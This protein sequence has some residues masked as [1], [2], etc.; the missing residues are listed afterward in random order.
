M[1]D[2]YNF[3][4]DGVFWQVIQIVEWKSHFQESSD[5]AE[6]VVEMAECT[7]TNHGWEPAADW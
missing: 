6:N 5:H 2:Y 1:N 3:E 4:V 7:G